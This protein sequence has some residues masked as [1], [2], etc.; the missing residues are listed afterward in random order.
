MLQHTGNLSLCKALRYTF[1]K[2][3]G[4]DLTCS[5]NRPQKAKKEPEL[6]I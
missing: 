2:L 3:S 4:S 6:L 1:A 5:L